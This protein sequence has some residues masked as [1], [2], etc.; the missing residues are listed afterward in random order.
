MIQ[1]LKLHQQYHDKLEIYKNIG[2]DQL[3][4]TTKTLD[5]AKTDEINRGNLVD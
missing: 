4:T 3:V 1:K 2:F 5:T